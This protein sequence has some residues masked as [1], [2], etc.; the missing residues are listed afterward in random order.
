MEREGEGV[1]SSAEA[2][3]GYPPYGRKRPLRRKEGKGGNER[4]I[5]LRLISNT[6]NISR[7]QRLMKNSSGR[8]RTL[9]PRKTQTQKTQHMTNI[10]KDLSHQD[11]VTS[12]YLR[13]T[14]LT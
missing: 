14:H 13:R 7:Y 5:D 9:S 3:A 4:M 6:I 2:P 12:A 10:S 1:L 11:G 8:S